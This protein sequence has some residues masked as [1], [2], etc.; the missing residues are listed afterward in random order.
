MILLSKQASMSP[1]HT[2][3]IS[4][5]NLENVPASTYKLCEVFRK[6]ALLMHC[7]RLKSIS[8]GGALKSLSLIT[9]LDL[10]SN[11]LDNLP[12]DIVNLISLK[13]IF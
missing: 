13:V 4:E 3:D 8:G 11:D 5:C 7:N 12:S 2:Y 10:H 1:S 9:H 6:E